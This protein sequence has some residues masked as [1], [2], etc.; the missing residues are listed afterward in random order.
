MTQAT[1]R[2]KQWLVAGLMGCFSLFAS[3]AQA[4]SAASDDA[5]N[6]SPGTFINGANEGSGFAPWE[7]QLGTGAQID[8]EDSTVGTGDI[9]SGNGYSFMV[10]GGDDGFGGSYADLTRP[11]GSALVPGDVFSFTMAYNW[12]GGIRGMALLR[13]GG[14]LMYLQYRG[15]NE[16][17]YGFA[18]GPDTVIS[19]DYLA[20]AVLEVSI[21]QL[22]GN[23]L[24]VTLSRNDGFTTNLVS[25]PLAGP[26][27]GIK[28][29]NGGHMADNLNYA[30]FVNDLEIVPSAIPSL[31][32]NGK[33]GMALITN[34]M[35][36][37]RGGAN[38]DAITVTLQ[39]SDPA[40]ASVPVSVDFVAGATATN[41]PIVGNGLGLVTV[42]ASAAGYPDSFFDVF[43]YDI[44]Y[45]DT[46]YYPP[47]LFDD[48]G[49]GG[50]GFQ[51]WIIINNNDSELG[52]FAGVFIGDSTFGGTDVNTAG[53]SFGL[54]AN[55]DDN[56][57]VDA[58]R[59]FAAELAVGQSISVEIGVNFRNG[60]K[61]VS[62]QSSGGNIFE[63]AV[64][65]DDYW[66]KIGNNAPV[67]LGWDYASDSAFE[68]ELS[69]LAGSLYDVTINRRGGTPESFA[70]NQVDLGATAPNEVKFFNVATEPGDENNL[71]ANRLAMYSSESIDL[72]TVDGNDGMVAGQVAT[73]TVTRSG[74]TDDALT[75]NL[76]S[77]DA[78]VATVDASVEIPAGLDSATFQVTAVANG[79]VTIEATADQY[80]GIAFDVLVVDIAYD[81]TTYYPTAIFADGGNGGVGFEPWIISLN[82]GEGEGYTNYV[83][84]FVGSSTS[85]G[86]DVNSSRGTAFGL[87][88]NRE[89][90]GGP[91][92]LAEATRPFADELGIGESIS[93]ALG[94]NFRNGAKGAMI[95]N[96]GTWLFEVAVFNDQYVYNIRSQGDNPVDLG[97]EYASDSAIIVTLSRMDASTYNVLIEREG[98]APEEVLLQGITLSSAPDRVRFY[99]Y[100]TDGGGDENN[101]YINALAIYT[102]T[103]GEEVTDG[104]PNSW[105]E[106][107]GVEPGDRVAGIDLDDDGASNLEEYLADTNPQDANS[108]F[109]EISGM[110]GGMV[111]SIQTAPTTNSRVYDIYWTTDLLA[112]P[113][114]WNALGN[115]TAGNNGVLTLTVT[116]DV[117][118]RIYRT[119]VAL[120]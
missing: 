23:A 93:F 41:F 114:Q 74:D 1:L 34:L 82:D 89:G 106:K 115:P 38:L 73:F 101:L 54:Y 2:G 48:A 10:Y 80:L 18:G 25:G 7:F 36:L 67:S 119:G 52:R 88:A 35:T 69:R 22:A 91:D 99:N 85:G 98:S 97:W 59:P 4:A 111:L 24:S 19:T 87:Y 3:T 42:L 16:L 29:Y 66:Y 12:N 31:E 9:N 58:I 56:P 26:A 44:A 77:T 81:D 104:I 112:S 6:Y 61:G 71:Y 109:G 64:F 20:D 21:E 103:V 118:V 45:D 120:P 62:F 28:F 47:G 33:E 5:G 94:V 39:S 110:T 117:P 46:S 68:I 100:F 57:F 49:N 108:V 78:G 102:G 92:P 11:F 51:P 83:G 60:S 32:L 8:L 27:T 17:A 50:A 86:S 30:L 37:T 90:E 63:F 105:W 15:G 53:A 116:N 95:Q 40:I 96:D 13:A 70:L 65:S 75:V 113:Q 76:A 55:G 14:E 84:A 72:L 107:W 43:V 79:E